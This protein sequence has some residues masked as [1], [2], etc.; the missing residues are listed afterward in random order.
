MT[1]F[2]AEDRLP[3]DPDRDETVARMIRVD[4]AG[5]YGAVRIYA[6]QRAFL[7]R[8][9]AADAVDEM[10]AREAEH[11]ETFDRL[12]AERGIRPTALMPLWHVAGFALGAAT[13]RPA[14]SRSARAAV[15]PGALTASVGK[16]A[17]ASFETGQSGSRGRTTESGPGQNRA[18]RACAASVHS[19]SDRAAA[20]SGTWTIRGLNSGR[21]LAS[22]TRAT[23][24]SSVASAPSP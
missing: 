3:G 19:T 6:G 21:F 20:M 2:T 23:A 9:A 11:L 24:R 7:R 14:F 22:N 15:P 13:G 4:Q 1:R 10:A 16:P 8:G 17:A 5:E 12:V 18:A